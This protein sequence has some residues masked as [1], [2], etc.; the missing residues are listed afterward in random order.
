MVRAGE[1]EA[2]HITPE[3]SDGFTRTGEASHPRP[4]AGESVVDKAIQKPIG[5]PA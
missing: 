4:L 5:I 1:R 3:R 2:N